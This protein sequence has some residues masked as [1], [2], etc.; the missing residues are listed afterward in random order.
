MPARRGKRKEGRQEG[1]EGDNTNDL[2]FLG[3]NLFDRGDTT[4]GDGFDA[5]VGPL[6]PALLTHVEEAVVGDEGVFEFGQELVDRKT[7]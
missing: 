1:R 3:T 4:A 7:E 2:L 6:A 5:I